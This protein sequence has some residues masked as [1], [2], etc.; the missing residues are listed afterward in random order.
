M[1]WCGVEPALDHAAHGFDAWMRKLAEQRNGV[2]WRLAA[3]G[4]VEECESNSPWLANGLITAGELNRAEC[5][6]ALEPHVVR[7]E[8]L[9]APSGAVRAEARAVVGDA[10]D[11]T[12]ET[13]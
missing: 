11:R 9:A 5:C 4:V 3:K 7:D 12:V 2:K 13:M 1:G 10:D 8:N 6:E